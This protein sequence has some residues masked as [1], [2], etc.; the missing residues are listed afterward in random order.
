MGSV[1]IALI[2]VKSNVCADWPAAVWRTG[3]KGRDLNGD[4]AIDTNIS[5]S[6]SLSS[7]TGC[8]PTPAPD[9]P[10][11]HHLLYKPRCL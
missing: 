1:R 5:A 6:S 10:F 8:R 9:S 7:S 11:S 4:T 3:H 2:A